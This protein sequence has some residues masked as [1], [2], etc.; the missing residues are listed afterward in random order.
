MQPHTDSFYRNYVIYAARNLTIRFTLLNSSVQMS[1]TQ[2]SKTADV[3]GETCTLHTDGIPPDT[4]IKVRRPGALCASHS[5][6]CTF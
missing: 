5:A 4:L 6:T 2:M 1:S 3:S